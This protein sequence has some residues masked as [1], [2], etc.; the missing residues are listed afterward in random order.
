MKQNLTLT[1]ILLLNV[2]GFSQTDEFYKIDTLFK[3]WNSTSTPGCAIGVINNNKVLFTKCYGMAS[4]DNNVPVSLN[5]RFSIGS[6]TKQFTAYCIAILIHQDKINLDDDIRLYLPEFPY[7][8]DTIR[9]R[10]LIYHTNGLN[11]YGNMIRI[12][13][14][15][16]DDVVTDQMIKEMIYNSSELHFKPGDKFEYSNSGYFLLAEIIENVSGLPIDEF[17][18]KN[19]FRP[20]GMND[21]Y[22]YT[23]PLPRSSIITI[24]YSQNV[25]GYYQRHTLN[26]VPLGSGN[27]ISTLHDLL[28]WEQNFYDDKLYNNELK[29]LILRKGILNNGD[30]TNYYFGLKSGTYKDY[31]TIYHHG[32]F[33]SFESVI[34]RIPEKRLSIIILSNDRIAKTYFD[35]YS[36]ADKIAGILLDKD[37]KPEVPDN[38]LNPLISEESIKRYVGTYKS[39]NGFSNICYDKGQLKISYSYGDWYYSIFPKSDSVFYDIY[40]FDAEYRFRTDENLNIIG[41]WTYYM[42]YMEKVNAD[43]IFNILDDYSGTFYSKGLNTIYL[44]YKKENKMYCKINSN[45]SHELIITGKDSFRYKRNTLKLLRNDLNEVIGLKINNRYCFNKLE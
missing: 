16:Y 32:D 35:N 44:L 24:S 7:T 37:Y 8:Q 29:K 40:D 21:T 26:T 25:F 23:E 28:I 34:L 22:Y 10:H 39:K 38:I 31:K 36:M 30:T 14:Y 4:L 6:L 42:N 27:V 1:L 12:C 43:S 9:I 19:I 13:G 3:N 5:S 18:E 20:L 33:N 45:A 41:L 11:E 17:A 2:C 15:T